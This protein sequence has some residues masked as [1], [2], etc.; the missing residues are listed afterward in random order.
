[1]E[2]LPLQYSQDWKSLDVSVLQ[3]LIFENHLHILNDQRERETHL[4]YERDELT[5]LE[6]VDSGSHQL[7]FF[8]NPT[9]VDELTEVAGGGER[10]PQKSTF[11]YPKLGTGLVMNKLPVK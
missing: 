5:A 4:A 6:M 8:L 10:M 11:F 9:K 1:M 7:A 3:V 2:K